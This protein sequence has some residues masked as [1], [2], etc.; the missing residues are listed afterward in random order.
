M[1]QGVRQRAGTTLNEH[2]GV[3]TLRSLEDAVPPVPSCLLEPVWSQFVALLPDRPAFDPMHPPGCHRRRIPDRVVFEHDVA[4]LVHGPGYERLATPCCSDRTIHRR[5]HEW[6]T[7]GL[8]EVL[9][10]PALEQYDHTLALEVEDLA[11]DGCITKAPC[12]GEKAGLPRM[13][14]HGL[15]HGTATM[16]LAQG[17]SQRENMAVLGHSNLS[18]TM[19]IYAHVA[20]E[21]MRENAERMQR[22]LGGPRQLGLETGVNARRGDGNR[23]L[24]DGFRI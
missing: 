12:G 16:P 14:L 17:A 8:T 9:H 24:L 5:V 4:A 7:A 1:G 23:L 2:G 18:T 13:P 6:A 10:M 19:N 22:A 15:R 20:P 3:T 11:V 21:L